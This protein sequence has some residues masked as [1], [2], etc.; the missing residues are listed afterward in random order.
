[1]KLNLGVYIKGKLNQALEWIGKKCT[2]RWIKLITFSEG[3][4]WPTQPCLGDSLDL[5]KFYYLGT[6]STRGCSSC[7][8]FLQCFMCADCWEI[9]PHPCSSTAG[10]TTAGNAGQQGCDLGTPKVSP[11]PSNPALREKLHLGK[12][13]M[14]LKFHCYILAENHWGW[15]AL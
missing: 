3:W 15:K 9:P 8:E 7:P 4:C 6:Q 2:R 14:R 5:L 1:M 11:S 13:K 10:E 12:I